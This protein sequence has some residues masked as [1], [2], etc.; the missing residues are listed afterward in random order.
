MVAIGGIADIVQH[1][2]EMAR[3]RMTQQRHW[4]CT[5]AMV[6]MPVQPLPKY[7]FEPLRCRL[8]ILGS[9]MKRREFITLLGGA[10]A[11]WPLAARAQQ[12]DRIPRV[13]VLLG[14]RENDP[15]AKTRVKAFQQG[16]RDLGWFESQNIRIDYRFAASNPDLINKYVAELVTLAPDVIVGNSTPV[17]AALRQ[18]TSSIP[19]VFAVL[20]DPVGQGFISSLARPGAN[21]TGFTFIDFPMVG[22]WLAM[23]KVVVPNLSR[24]MLMFNPATSPYYDVFLRSFETMPSSI[25]AAVWAM[26]VRD[27][28]D[29]AGAIAKLGGEPNSGL[30]AAADIFVVDNLNEI[31]QLTLQH[32][33]PAMSAYRQFVVD[34]GLMSYGPD[35]AD[36]FRRAAGY[37][38]RILRGSKPGDLPAQSPIKFELAINLKTATALG[39]TAPQSLLATADEVIE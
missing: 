16:L 8:L 18:K 15:E 23:L 32:R 26:P 9:D 4:P 27:T 25:N 19:I 14:I 7:S 10:A 17:L 11:A 34:G 29:M 13:G 2:H 37:V 28:A 5:A 12:T 21:I 24:A 35:T 38:D 31:A 30:I 36:I 33:V 3:S 39:L 1:W 20:N 6:L 22:K